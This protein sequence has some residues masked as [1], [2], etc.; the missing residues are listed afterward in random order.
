MQSV[1]VLVCGYNKE[2][3]QAIKAFLDRTLDA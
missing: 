3:A 1:G 2:D